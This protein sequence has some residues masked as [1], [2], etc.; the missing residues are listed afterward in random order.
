MGELTDGL[1]VIRHSA[2]PDRAY[3]R[4]Y[5]GEG[6]RQPSSFDDWLLDLID[7]RPGMSFLDVACG[8]AQLPRQAA[9]CRMEAHGV[10]YSRVALRRGGSSRQGLL[11]AAADGE[12]L[13]Y[14]D[15]SFD[16]VASIGSLE[17][18]ERPLQG[19]RE[20]SRVL[21]ADGVAAVLL[22]NSF[23]LRWNVLYTWRH[24]DIH[25][26][27]QPLQRYGTRRQWEKLL[28]AGGLSV[29]QTVGYE[30]VAE[31]AGGLSAML[32]HPSRFLI[33][34]SGLLPVNMAS[35]FVFVCRK[36]R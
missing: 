33:P 18:Y 32:R 30:G 21:K 19:A 35:M 14:A 31:Q 11:L 16:R 20:L 9:S 22:P 3:D 27:G 8:E 26:D 10:D 25:D 6:I 12:A 17:H 7:A 2:M 1:L 24:G 36:S 28:E 4:I 23:G 5:A 15:E 29:R 13:P 34:L